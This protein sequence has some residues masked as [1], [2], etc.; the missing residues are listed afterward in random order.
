MPRY[1]GTGPVWGGG[2]GAGWGAGPCGLGLR[3]GMGVGC[4]RGYNFRRWTKQD[5][6]VALEEEI[7][8][9][10]EELQAAEEG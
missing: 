1:D 10:K 4:G 9:L 8:I 2:P 5:E 6:K 3:H 7:K